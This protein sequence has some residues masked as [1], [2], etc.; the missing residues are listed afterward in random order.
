MTGYPGG[1]DAAITQKTMERDMARKLRK[2]IPDP[3]C[4]WYLCGYHPRVYPGTLTPIRRDDDAPT[5]LR[6]QA[7][8]K[9]RK[10]RASECVI[11]H[12]LL[13]C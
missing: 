7:E 9:R 6:C 12:D 1:R 4:G 2:H 13:G 11:E 5:C 10:L 3:H 8:R